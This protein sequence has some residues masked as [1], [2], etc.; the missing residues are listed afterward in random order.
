MLS[1]VRVPPNVSTQRRYEITFNSST[2]VERCQSDD[3]SIK[4]IV[5]QFCPIADIAQKAKDDVVDVLAIVTAVGDVTSINT[6]RGEALAKRNVTLLDATA[7]TI[8]LTLWGAVAENFSVPS[9]P[10]IAVRTRCW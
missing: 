1:R 5:Y 4:H 8:E 3:A 7:R 10:V 2:R 6:K 9:T